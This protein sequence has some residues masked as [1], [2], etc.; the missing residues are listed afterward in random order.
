MGAG[1][2]GT[3]WG[4]LW[5]QSIG[6]GQGSSQDIAGFPCSL[7]ILTQWHW[8]V[9]LSF[10]AFSLIS[11]QHPRVNVEVARIYLWTVFID[12]QPYPQS[13]RSL[14]KP[15]EIATWLDCGETTC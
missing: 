12:R 7:K 6:Q 2:R 4:M 11:S 5:A 8:G 1:G 15:L 14:P 3:G 10:A 9:V 13:L